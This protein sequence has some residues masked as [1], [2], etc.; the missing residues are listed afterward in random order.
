MTIKRKLSIG[1]VDDKIEVMETETTLSYK[2][3]H[4]AYEEYLLTSKI[5]DVS[6]ALKEIE[7]DSEDQF[8]ANLVCQKDRELMARSLIEKIDNDPRYWKK[9][10][11]SVEEYL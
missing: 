9:V 1:I 11:E 6:Q 3:L 5:E 8:D 10:R 2:E 7:E 4:D